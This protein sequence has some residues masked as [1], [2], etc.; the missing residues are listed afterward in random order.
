MRGAHRIRILGAAA[1]MPL[2]TLMLAPHTVAQPA[3]MPLLTDTPQYC[4]ELS[5]EVEEVRQSL[6]SPA[7]P[8]VEQLAEEGRRLCAMGEIRGGIV[9][10]R[11]AM[12]LLHEI[13]GQS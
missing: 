6:V 5:D 8:E 13:S 4:V 12:V 10:L 7:P 1:A 9:R 3:P 11:R 2:I